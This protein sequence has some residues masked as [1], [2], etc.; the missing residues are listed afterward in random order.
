VSTSRRHRSRYGRAAVV[1]AGLL[2]FLLT[3]A[4]VV[5]VV[6]T[7]DRGARRSA[8]QQQATQLAGAARVSVSALAALRADLRAQAGE[9]A[10]S[11]PLQQALVAG[12]HRALE[13]IVR[14]RRAR[15]VAG[16][17]AFGALSAGPKL[18]ASASIDDGRTRLAR[19]T[20][21]VP[22]DESVLTLLRQSTPLTGHMALILLRH[23]R[24]LAGGPVGARASIRHGSLA[25]GST[26]FAARTVP[27]SGVDARVVAVEPLSAI[28]ERMLPY[29]R[30]LLLAAAITLALAA[31]LA[32]VLGRP[33][34]R[35][36]GEV[37]R[38][39]WQAQTDALT[40]LAN[41]RALDERLDDE[42][43]R[44][45]RLGTNLSFV[46]AD[47]DAFKQINDR[48]GHTTGDAVLQAVARVFAETVRELDLAARYG[49]EE[50]ALV[51]PGTPLIGARRL[52]ERIRAAVEKLSVPNA[53]G[54][55]VTVTLSFGAAAFPTYADASELVEAADTALYE[56]KQTGKNRVVTATARKK[57]ASRTTVSPA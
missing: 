56:A 5:A 17:A 10:S 40:K 29:R 42:V 2:V 54:E 53:D 21:A 12:D 11:L 9:L 13:R 52:A 51:L 26:T 55:P 27:A 6:V 45:R 36:L 34:A 41:R 33:M 46:I 1:R 23:G 32:T 47:I 44:A 48:H 57:T 50:L 38:L 28:D 49:G 14:I 22:L 43:E 7:L 31:G 3:A 39:K 18:A 16:G 20:I 15:L 8:E 35:A 37:T 30:R 19:I 4:L 25:L 24:V